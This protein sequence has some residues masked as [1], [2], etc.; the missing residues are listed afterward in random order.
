MAGPISLEDRRK[1][2]A[3]R[4]VVGDTRNLITIVDV[5]DAVLA[6]KPALEAI[7]AVRAGSLRIEYVE[8]SEEEKQEAM[9]QR[10]T[11]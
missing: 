1:K 6:I 8:I 5:D 4:L 11:T 2:P 10:S 3:F 7:V 9:A